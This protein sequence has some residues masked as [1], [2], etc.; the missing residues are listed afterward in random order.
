MNNI[1]TFIA[2]VRAFVKARKE[3]LTKFISGIK[4]AVKKVIGFFGIIKGFFKNLFHHKKR[5]QEV[6]AC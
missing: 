3:A 1:K 5:L 4:V 2:K 6:E